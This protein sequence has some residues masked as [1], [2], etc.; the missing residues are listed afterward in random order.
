MK[1][2]EY[3]IKANSSDFVTAVTKA[4]TI[5]GQAL[6]GMADKGVE[7]RTCGTCLNF[8]GLTDKL[9]VGTV[10]NMYEIVETLAKAG[11]VIKP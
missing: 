3:L 4:E 9:S 1:T 2:L 6:K 5:Y 11:K 10:T 7:I 8:Y